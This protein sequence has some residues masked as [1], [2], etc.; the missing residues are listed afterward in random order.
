MTDHGG[1]PSRF[2]V[3]MS[4][5]VPEPFRRAMRVEAARRGMSM[6]QL[7]QDLFNSRTTMLRRVRDKE[8]TDGP[9]T[10]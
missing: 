7:F 9:D 2:H 3:R 8:G 1:R 10:D 5:Y 4:G 6:G